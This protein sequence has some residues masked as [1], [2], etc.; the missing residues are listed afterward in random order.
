MSKNLWTSDPR[1]RVLALAGG[2][3]TLC[4]VLGGCGPAEDDAAI[5]DE[6]PGLALRVLGDED[7]SASAQRAKLSLSA[8]Q[9]TFKERCPGASGTKT[10][11]LNN[12]GDSTL[13]IR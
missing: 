4:G 5:G 13:T 12:T 2:L 1:R 3:L 11:E 8:S 10:L 6:A 7:A 9:L